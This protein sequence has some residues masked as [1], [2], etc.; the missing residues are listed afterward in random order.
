LAL[1]FLVKYLYIPKSRVQRAIIGDAM[2]RINW[3]V[4]KPLFDDVDVGLGVTRFVL[5][6]G[7]VVLDGINAVCVGTGVVNVAIWKLS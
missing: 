6:G 1:F 4:V 3:I 5:L 2:D 7:N